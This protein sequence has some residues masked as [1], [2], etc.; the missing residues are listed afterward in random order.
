M[1]LIEQIKIVKQLLEA[2]KEQNGEY[3]SG[4]DEDIED[5]EKLLDYLQSL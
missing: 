2:T 4:Y 5:G 3:E 1:L